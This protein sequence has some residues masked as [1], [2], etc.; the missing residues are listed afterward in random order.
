M[1]A[2]KEA[3]ET[4]A[5][6]EAKELA[7]AA[8]KEEAVRSLPCMN[9]LCANP[10]LRVGQCAASAVAFAAPAPALHSARR[11]LHVQRRVACSFVAAWVVCRLPHAGCLMHVARCLLRKYPRVPWST[12]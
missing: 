1:A 7:A 10:A 9:H 6:K 2:N 5:K 11:V 3:E 12:V 8:K 4:A